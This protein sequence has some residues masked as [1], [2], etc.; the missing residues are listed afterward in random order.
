[1]FFLSKNSLIFKSLFIF[2]GFFLAT[3]SYAA[4]LHFSPS[5]DNF[6]VGNIFKV[7]VLVDSE[8]E[9]I[10]SAETVINFPKNL[11]EAVSVSKFKSIFSMWAEEPTFS[12]ADGQIS[13]VGGLPTPG[14]T[15]INGK[16]LEI[17]FKT[18]KAGN[19]R[20]LFSSGAVYA[21][22]GFGTDVL[23]NSYQANFALGLEKQIKNIASA[24]LF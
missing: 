23:A 2:F 19:A 15:G 13:F 11:L 24:L 16:V 10:N 18:K 9:S 12:N 5:T 4:D 17:V 1:M 6:N 8:N 14:F 3:N 20:L 21:N 22:D 7:S